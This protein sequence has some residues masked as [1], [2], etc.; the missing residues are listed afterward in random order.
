MIAFFGQHSPFLNFYQ[1]SFEYDGHH[2]KTVEHA[3]Q[4]TKVIMFKDVQ[5]AER[6]LASD[7]G[8]K[9]NNLAEK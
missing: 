9:Q 6:I 1:A 5:T 3:I 7:S 2:F 4:H 8:K